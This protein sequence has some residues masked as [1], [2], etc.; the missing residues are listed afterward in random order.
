M[1]RD[2]GRVDFYD[3]MNRRTEY[4]R[5]DG[6]ARSNRLGWMASDRVRQSF[7]S[8]PRATACD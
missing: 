3:T 2:T 1:D 8:Y 4:S 5:V 6:R 7:R